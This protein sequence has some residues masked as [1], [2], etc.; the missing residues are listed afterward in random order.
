M[1]KSFAERS[2]D[3]QDANIGVRTD[4]NAARFF[5]GW[6]RERTQ[7]FERDC[8]RLRRWGWKG[9][10]K[11][12]ERFRV[13]ESR[14]RDVQLYIVASDEYPM[15]PPRVFAAERGNMLRELSKRNLVSLAKW[16]PHSTLVKVAS[17]ASRLLEE[18]S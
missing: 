18:R 11:S 12:S 9:C 7:R 1:T 4:S 17:E 3:I 10:N 2:L 15:V 8:T 6:C 16:T 13:F 14:R 5:A